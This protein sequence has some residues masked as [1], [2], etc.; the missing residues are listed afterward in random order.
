MPKIIDKIKSKIIV[1]AK[2][3]SSENYSHDEIKGKPSPSKQ[4][5]NGQHVR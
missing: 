2:S 5:N 4:P 3:P 1:A